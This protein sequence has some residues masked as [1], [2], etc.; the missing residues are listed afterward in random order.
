MTKIF[1]LGD[2]LVGKTTIIDRYISGQF[3]EKEPPTVNVGFYS[4]NFPDSNK[5]FKITDS[6]GQKKFRSFLLSYLRDVDIHV[7]VYDI[8]NRNSFL[9]LDS[10]LSLIGE[11]VN[12]P[13]FIVGN[14][15]DLSDKR[16][17]S[18][19]EA[20]DYA[21]QHQ[22]HFFEVSCL[23]GTNIDSLFTEISQV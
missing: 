17:V 21:K 18:E 2:S 19:D 7:L 10:W 6:S 22:F 8:T 9:N 3:H 1:F 20:I 5:S 16:E 15:A 13:I 14:K 12:T 23:D 11:N 4:K